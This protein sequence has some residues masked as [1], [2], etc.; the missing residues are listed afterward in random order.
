MQKESIKEF[1]QGISTFGWKADFRA[2]C[3]VC[4][5]HYDDSD[6][7]YAL[8]KWNDFKMLQKGLNAFDLTVL[9]AIVQAGNGDK[10]D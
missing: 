4:G 5:F 2:F 3:E 10:I 6:G 7:S 9:S 8:Q 1:V